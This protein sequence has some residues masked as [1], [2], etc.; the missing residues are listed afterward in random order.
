MASK[1]ILAVLGWNKRMLRLT[2]LTHSRVLPA[3]PAVLIASMPKSG[4]T[5]LVTAIAE[6]TGFR[7]HFLGEH[8]MSEQDL[9]EA[10]ILD[11]RAVATVVHQH[12][13]ANRPNLALLRKYGLRVVFQHR[14]LDDILVSIQ[15]KLP[16]DPWITPAYA[17]GPEFLALDSDH[18]MDLIIELTANRYV[19]LY[20]DWWTALE[21][22][23]AEG[24]AVGYEAMNADKAATVQ[25]VLKTF[26]L[27]VSP[28]RLA[29]A[30][31][32]AEG[33]GDTRRNRAEVGRGAT[34]L[35]DR[36]RARLNAMTAPYP[37][38]DFSPIGLC[39]AQ[40][41][42]RGVMLSRSPHDPMV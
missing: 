14:R 3:R 19:R 4:S 16:N 29:R 40:P 32:T 33:S 15:D 11:S 37:W 25:T 13:A 2:R 9:S 39:P 27:S 20:A 10:A 1:L 28:E 26:D 42:A 17:V 22:G 35:L 18:Q 38:V 41:K 6:A 12:F 8:F 7:R 23:D 21:R 36:H 31:A 5:F 24:R 34:R 30:V